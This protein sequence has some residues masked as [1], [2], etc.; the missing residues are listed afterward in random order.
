[1]LSG[2]AAPFLATGVEEVSFAEVFRNAFTAIETL[3]AELPPEL[4]LIFKQLF[5]FEGYTKAL[6]PDLVIPTDLYLIRNVLPAEVAE[7][8]DQL[9]IELPT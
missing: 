4:V 3:G 8:V 9:G 5:Y 2:L 7:R 6:A 1:M